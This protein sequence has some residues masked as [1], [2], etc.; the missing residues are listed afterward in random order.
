MYEA[1]PTLVESGL[2]IQANHL[3]LQIRLSHLKKQGKDCV[4]TQNILDRLAPVEDYISKEITNQLKLHAAYPWFSRVKGIGN[5]NIAKVIGLVRVAPENGIEGDELPYAQTISA[6]WKFAG[7]AP[8]NGQAMKKNKGKKLEYNAT[9]RVMCWRLGSSLLRAKG[10]FYDYYNAQKYRYEQRLI[11]EGKTIV[12]AAYLPKDE[13]NK[14]TETDKVISEGHVH[15]YALRKMIKLFLSCLWLEWRAG[16]DLPV[17]E[18]YAM[19]QLK[20][21]SII[22]PEDMIDKPARRIKKTIND[23]RARSPK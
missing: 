19:D 16:L 12:P 14:R 9:L 10:K 17:T 13:Q 20:H 7:Y 3:R 8:V 4:H 2:S 5:E 15:N 11:N 22:K 21:N 18:P 6:L 1:L 23:K